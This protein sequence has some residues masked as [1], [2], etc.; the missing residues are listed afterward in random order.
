MTSNDESRCTQ[1]RAP[2]PFRM[3]W[4]DPERRHF[5]EEQ[6]GGGLTMLFDVAHGLGVDAK[7]HCWCGACEPAWS[8]LL[9]E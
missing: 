2:L 5:V 4:Q 6:G 8:A 3:G 7:A 1:R 9:H